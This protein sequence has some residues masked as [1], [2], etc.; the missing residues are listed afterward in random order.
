[1]SS[2]AGILKGKRKRKRARAM[3][4]CIATV[5]EHNTIGTPLTS[6]AY[7]MAVA[8]LFKCVTSKGV[9]NGHTS[10]KES[11]TTLNQWMDE[12]LRRYNLPYIV[13]IWESPHVGVYHVKVTFIGAMDRQDD[14]VHVLNI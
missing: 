8:N 4:R 1:M 10:Q 11:C 14:L 12:K 6:L 3:E 9:I 13:E 5:K 2:Q 7:R